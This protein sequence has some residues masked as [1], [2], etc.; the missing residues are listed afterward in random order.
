M[1]KSCKLIIQNDYEYLPYAAS[2]LESTAE[3]FGL[4]K[5]EIF[6]IKFAVEETLTNTISKSFEKDEIAEIKV[7]INQVPGG[8]EVVISDKGMPFNPFVRNG[9]LNA[10]ISRESDQEEISRLL[11][12]KMLNKAVFNNL[13]KAG[14]EARL[15][16]YSENFRIENLINKSETPPAAE[17]TRDVF[18][19]VRLFK[20]EDAWEISKLFYRSYGYSY[21]NEVVYYP[22]RILENIKK[23]KMHSA[24]AVSEKNK[25]VGFVSIFEPDSSNRITEF[26]MAVN[27]PDY[28]G[29]GIMNYNVEFI[30]NRA[31][32]LKYSGIFAH[33]VTNHIFTQKTMAK[34]GF[35][36][37]ALMVGYAP[38][39][40]FKKINA[41]LSQRESTFIEF[42]YFL[43]PEKTK[44]F[45]PDKYKNI[46]EEIYNSLSADF[47]LGKIE[48]STFNDEN[49]ITENMVGAL[50]SVEI[51]VKK[52]GRNFISEITQITKNHCQNKIDNIYLC[53]DL[54]DEASMSIVKEI[55]KI[56]YFLA[57]VLPYY[58]FPHTIIFQYI[59]NCK[60]DYDKILSFSDLAFKIKEF[61]QRFD[62]NQ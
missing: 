54:E 3:S 9:D 50:N 4:S 19:T 46:I 5:K 7:K 38:D 33:S 58:V 52:I 13:G 43:K 22:D 10:K 34:Y 12:H 36:T 60:Y 42:Q 27:D 15:I 24:V 14:K 21:V 51:F 39:L 30:M 37:C 11:I 8:I 59:N 29:Q 41:E 26:G 35:V 49:E 23:G 62:P 44:L 45:I 47:E 61:T 20:P 32:E 16:L 48:V 18:K 55:E 28:R 57:G 53:L 6:K 56:G 40:S 17:E 31:R 25:I 1:L 2:L